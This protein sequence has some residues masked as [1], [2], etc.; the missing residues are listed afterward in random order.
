MTDAD[1]QAAIDALAHRLRK[2]DEAI[3]DGAEYA[4]ADPFSLEFITALRAQGWR[5]TPAKVYQLP[6]RADGG[7]SDGPSE[8]YRAIRARWEAGPH[9]H[10]S[11]DNSDG[12]A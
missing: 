2:R 5:V 11:R 4:D 12:A 10:R 6:Q 8:D 3:R 1:T 7:T 9:P